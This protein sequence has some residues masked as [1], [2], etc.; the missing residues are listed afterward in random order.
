MEMNIN[1][2]ALLARIKLREDEKKSLS[3]DLEKILDYIKKLNELDTA[4]IPPTSHVLAI[5][6]VF[7]P[8]SAKP[9]DIYKE[10]L[11]HAPEREGDFFK[12]PKVIEGE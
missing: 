2:V 4:Q 9:Q 8:D 12:V 5:E 6:N 1:Q 10:A 7:R 3:R 11:G